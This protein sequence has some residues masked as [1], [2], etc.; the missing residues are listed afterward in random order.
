L[1]YP[2]VFQVIKTEIRPMTHGPENVASRATNR[3][4]KS[5]HFSRLYATFWL[6]IERFSNQGRI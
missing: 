5:H 1:S 3:Q 2:K 4:I 6:V